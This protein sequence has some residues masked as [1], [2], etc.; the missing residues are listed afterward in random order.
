[1]PMPIDCGGWRDDADEAS[2]EPLTRAQAQ[3]LR[4][5]LPS[6]WRLI[7]AQAWV[8]LAVAALCWG[9]S[10][11]IEAGWSALYGA[12]VA[13]VPAGVMLW[14]IGQSSGVRPATSMVRFMAW[15]TVKVMLAV[16]LLLLG[17]RVLPQLSWPALLVALAVCINVNWLLPLWRSR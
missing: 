12:A 8:G 9:V 15:E 3:A 1:M 14:G 17:S 4:A 11:R 16:T 7:A 5:K 6:P 10:A 2:I 13:V